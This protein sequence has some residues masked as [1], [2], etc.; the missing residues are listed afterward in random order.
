MITKI[1][2]WVDVFFSSQ[3]KRRFFNGAFWNGLGNGVSRVVTLG[4]SIFLARILGKDNFGEYG[5]I[6]TTN[7]M[8][9]A[10]AG[11]GIGATTTKYVAQFRNFDKEKVGRILGLSTILTVASGI[12][13]GLLLFFLAPLFAKIFHAPHL[14]LLFKISAISLALNVINGAQHGTLAGFEA[15][16]SMAFVNVIF[17]ISQALLVIGGAILLGILGVVWGM[18][19]S[20]L[21]LTMANWLILMYERRRFNINF[22]WRSVWSEWDILFKFSLPALMM[23]LIAGP[24]F[25]FCNMLLGRQ[26]NGIAEIGILS[27]ANQWYFACMFIPG[28][29]VTALLPIL[30]EKETAEQGVN[31]FRITSK[32]AKIIAII[33]MPSCG[34]ICLLSPWIM[35]AYGDDFVLG[36]PVL[37]CSVI[38]AGVHAVITPFWIAMMSKGAMWTCFFMN[39]GLSLTM[40]LFSYFF[41]HYGALGISFA[42]LLSYLFQAIAVVYLFMKY[43]LSYG[44][45]IVRK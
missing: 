23:A 12:L 6:Q 27:A 7:V 4:T 45:N 35:Q 29:L 39:L 17:S 22:F 28:L 40:L 18:T 34:A 26:P 44:L 21:V 10:V 1:T 13:C 14:T 3:T 9:I 43:R 36:V 5:I 31:N 19:G 2:S 42:R 11:L 20:C 16:K 33:S 30:S 37:I 15:Y 32:I 41:V 25:W 24:T 8:F 38:T